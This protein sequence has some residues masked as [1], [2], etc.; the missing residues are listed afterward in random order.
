[1]SG[2]VLLQFAGSCVSVM[3]RVTI[4]GFFSLLMSMMRAIGYGVRPA[5]HAASRCAWL[6]KPPEPAS[7][8]KI[9]YGL[10]RILTLMVCCA[11]EPSFHNN[12]LISFACG[13]GLRFWMSLRS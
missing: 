6:E 13:L 3:M 5:A 7:S 2:S 9:T 11:A 10:P 4:F 1:R 8:T 12:E